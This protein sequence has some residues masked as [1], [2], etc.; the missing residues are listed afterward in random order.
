LIARD[1]VLSLLCDRLFGT[2][3]RITTFAALRN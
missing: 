3:Y 1:H 2:K